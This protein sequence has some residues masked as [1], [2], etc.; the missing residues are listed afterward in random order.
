MTD[1]T[2]VDTPEIPVTPIASAPSFTPPPVV[3]P[4]AVD[5]SHALD[6]LPA[7][8]TA[9]KTD[10]NT[11]LTTNGVTG[12][13]SQQPIGRDDATAHLPVGTTVTILAAPVVQPVTS[14]ALTL[15]A[16]AHR[17]AI[18]VIGS[19]FHSALAAAWTWILD[20]E[21]TVADDLKSL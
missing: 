3:L 15:P 21:R 20:A 17:S 7:G 18:T 12:L 14:V 5:S 1:P 16:N 9:T 2:H 13:Q 6:A 19:S 11:V 4:F 8:S 10:A